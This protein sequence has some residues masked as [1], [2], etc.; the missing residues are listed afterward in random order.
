MM[1]SGIEEKIKD[2]SVVQKR[3]SRI[4]MNKSRMNFIGG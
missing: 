3:T 2:G 1:A 4:S